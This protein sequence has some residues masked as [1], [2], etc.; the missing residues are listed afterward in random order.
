MKIIAISQRGTKEILWLYSGIQ[1]IFEPLAE[2]FEL[3]PV[4]Y[5]IPEHNYHHIF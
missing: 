4:Q 2:L 3:L 1:N 5:P